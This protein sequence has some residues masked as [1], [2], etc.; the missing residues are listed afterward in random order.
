MLKINSFPSTLSSDIHFLPTLLQ[1]S[2]QKFHVSVWQR[3]V[4]ALTRRR[5][6]TVISPQK[7]RGAEPLLVK[8]TNSS[9]LGLAHQ[10]VPS[11]HHRART[12]RKLRPTGQFAA[13]LPQLLSTCMKRSGSKENRDLWPPPPRENA[14]SA[15]VM[16]APRLSISAIFTALPP[17]LSSPLS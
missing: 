2:P 11:N 8:S 12:A 4:T 16:S 14:G 15:R 9:A 17:L 7:W 3:A 5:W 1:F 13:W 10:D 6:Y